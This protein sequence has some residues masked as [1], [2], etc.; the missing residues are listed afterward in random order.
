MSDQRADIMRALI[1][2]SIIS[3]M[4]IPWADFLAA[5]GKVHTKAQC[6]SSRKAGAPKHCVVH[7]PSRHHMADWPLVLRAGSLLERTCPHGVG[8]PDPDSAAYL[9]WRDEEDTW[10]IHGC[11]GCCLPPGKVAHG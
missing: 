9:N 10:S 1:R 7:N 4:S 2:E 5:G 3:E 6:A 11:D 8:H